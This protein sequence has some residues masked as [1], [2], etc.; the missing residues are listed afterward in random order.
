VSARYMVTQSVGQA[1]HLNN[2]RQNKCF[3]PHF[4]VFSIHVCVSFYPFV[5][6]STSQ[7]NLMIVYKN[8]DVDVVVVVM[9]VLIL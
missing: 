2:S 6:K 9:L 7:G 1:I 4:I 5:F 8:C 3:L